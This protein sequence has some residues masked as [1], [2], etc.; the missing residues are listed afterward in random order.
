MLNNPRTSIRVRV[1]LSLGL[2]TV[3]MALILAWIAGDVAK[4]QVEHEQGH[5]LQATA[6]RV[7]ETLDQGLF[8]R[9]REIQILAELSD[10]RDPRIDVAAKRALLERVQSTHGHHAWIGL[11]DA[12]GV[13][14]VGTQGYLEGRNISARPWFKHG[15]AGPYVGD[16]HD[17]LLLAKM[18]P[19]PSGEQTY[20]LDVAA[21]VRRADGQV[22][23]VLCSHLQWRWTRDML[24]AAVPAGI[25]PVLLTRDGMVLHAAGYQMFDPFQGRSPKVDQILREYS[26]G[27]Y[28]TEWDNGRTY[29]TAHVTSSGYQSYPGLGWRLILRQDVEVA[30]AA[31]RA[32]QQRILW[33]G[34]GLGLLFAALGWLIAGRLTRPIEVLTAAAERISAK[35]LEGSL[36]LLGGRDELARLS[37]ALARML[38]E[39]KGEIRVRR[40]AEGKLK[41]AATVFEHSLEGIVITDVDNQVVSVNRAFSQ[42]TGYASGEIVGRSPNILNSGRHGVEFYQ[43]MWGEL[44]AHGFWQGEIWN[45]RKNGE[46]Y[47]EGLSISAV[48]NEEGA[49]SHY[50]GVFSDITDRKESE[51]RIRFL[52][53]H[54]ALTQLPNRRLFNDR[55]EQALARARRSERH[56]AVI[57][58]DLDHFKNINDTLGHAMGDEF[59]RLMA[60]RLRGSL[61]PED[62]LARVGGDEFLA[63]VEEEGGS[64]DLAAILDRMLKACAEPVTIGEHVLH[65]TASIGVAVFPDDGADI[66]T[67]VKNADIAM[68]RA[69]EVGRNNYQFYLP[70]FN[71]RVVARMAMEHTLRRALADGHFELHYQPQVSAVSGQVVGVEALL[72]LRDPARGLVMPGEF[73]ALAEETGLIVPI[74]D[75]VLRE[76]VRQAM[77]WYDAGVALR[78]SVNVSSKQLQRPGWGRDVQQLLH[79]AGLPP[80]LLEIELTESMVMEAGELERD[81]IE[82]LNRLGLEL[83]LDDF[84]TGYSSLAYLH[85]LRV[86]EL[87]IDRSFVQN[88]ETPD[89]RMLAEAIV[90]M[91]R[92]LGLKTVAEGVETAR[93]TDLLR[94]MGVDLLQG[95][96]FSV[97]VPVRE[98]EG[99]LESQAAGALAAA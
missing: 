46:I 84:G 36:P 14:R 59:L 87:K 99:L 74:G 27:F 34:L 77:Q 6:D 42:I 15:L 78:M 20:L 86:A 47:P 71:A 97:P 10:L 23:G 38:V 68:Y 80:H 7:M 91:A 93:Q 95:Y 44:H 39:L 16:V 35:N 64:Y 73:I 85:R 53:Y 30:F 52:A 41:L 56:V 98:L 75:W 62:T 83:S 48:K 92:K 17:A 76:A 33:I 88:L 32:L 18:L 22:A 67:L 3:S 21:P 43:T 26:E 37:G 63:L 50:V 40:A 45:R 29:L 60:E 9:Y 54:D 2:I 61:R 82:A 28:L 55:A 24:Q 31:A 1:S 13:A 90:S 94:A 51:N 66:E 79:E 12:E 96:Y 11:A 81:N 57:F 25:E 58:L 89:G 65:T 49:L 70:V 69:K 5:L 8:E 19:N 4:H 72:R